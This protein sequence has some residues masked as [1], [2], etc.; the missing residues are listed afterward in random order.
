MLI[1]G[2]PDYLEEQEDRRLVRRRRF[3]HWT[4]LRYIVTWCVAVEPQEEWMEDINKCPGRSRQALSLGMVPAM[5]INWR[6]PGTLLRLSRM[7]KADGQLLSERN[8]QRKMEEPGIQVAG[9]SRSEE[10]KQGKWRN[11]ATRKDPRCSRMFRKFHLCS[12]CA[13]K[14]SLI[15]YIYSQW[16]KTL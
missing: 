2:R 6:N 11:P 8:P 1:K 10:S 12:L 4:A 14:F 15:V 7:G 16:A 13:Y 3:F 9:N 5:W